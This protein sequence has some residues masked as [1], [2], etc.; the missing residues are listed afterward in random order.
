[1]SIVDLTKKAMS[2]AATSGGFRFPQHKNMGSG[3]QGPAPDA[4]KGTAG[5]RATMNMSGV[6][7]KPK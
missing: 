7:N 2:N 5:G 1:M 6:G 3:P 4:S